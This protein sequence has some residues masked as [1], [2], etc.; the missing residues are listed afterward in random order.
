MPFLYHMVPEPMIGTV[1][2]PMNSL[3][4]TLPETYALEAKKYEGRDSVMSQRVFPL[5]CLWNDV[6]HLTA[7]PPQVLKDTMLKAGRPGWRPMSFYQI[8]PASLDATLATVYRYDRETAGPVE[9]GDFSPFDPTHFDQYA[10]LP[11]A[12]EA[13]YVRLYAAGKK[14]LLFHRVPHILYKGPIDVTDA[15]IVT[16]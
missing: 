11:P 16:V 14:P 13:Y 1:L 15:P 9:A 4:E 2:Y 10:A 8:D 3:K 12:A 7:V 5:D 6:L